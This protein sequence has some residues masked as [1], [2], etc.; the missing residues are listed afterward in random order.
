MYIYINVYIC[1]YIYRYS[2][3]YIYRNIYTYIYIYI[4]THICIYV[5]IYLY[6]YHLSMPASLPRLCGEEILFPFMHVRRVEIQR[7]RFEFPKVSKYNVRSKLVPRCSALL[8][9]HCPCQLRYVTHQVASPAHTAGF[10]GQESPGSV[11][12]SKHVFHQVGPVGFERRQAAVSQPTIPAFII[13]GAAVLTHYR[14]ALLEGTALA[15]LHKYTAATQ[16]WV[17]ERRNTR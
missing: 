6:I 2:Y 7:A 16:G 12:T 13:S 15:P 5:C 3:V 11:G 1:I 17:E 9:W 14:I 4:Y 10:R 8:S